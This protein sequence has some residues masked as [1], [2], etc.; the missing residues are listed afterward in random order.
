MY[1]SLLNEDVHLDNGRLMAEAQ[2]QCGSPMDGQ[3]RETDIYETLLGLMWL[4]GACD[5]PQELWLTLY[6]S[7]CY[8]KSYLEMTKKKKKV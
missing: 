7:G 8:A 3:S 5:L 6:N 2:D 4:V 1:F